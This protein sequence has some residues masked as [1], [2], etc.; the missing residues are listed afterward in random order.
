MKK[1]SGK[2]LT[3]PCQ[4]CQRPCNYT[5]CGPYRQWINRCWNQYRRWSQQQ[6]EQRKPGQ[7]VWRYDPPVLLEDFLRDGPCGRCHFQ[8]HCKDDQT[9]AAYDA[10]IALCWKL[11]RR[12]LGCV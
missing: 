10:W 8:P 1:A 5:Q 11:L 3:S 4:G 6:P 2:N 12:R 7:D 9:C